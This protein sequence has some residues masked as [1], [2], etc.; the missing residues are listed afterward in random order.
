MTHYTESFDMTESEELEEI[1]AGI[2]WSLHTCDADVIQNAVKAYKFFR[3]FGFTSSDDAAEQLS[4]TAAEF[5]WIA[6]AL[7]SI[8]LIEFD[9]ATES[10]VCTDCD[11]N[12]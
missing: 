8:G 11:E 10:W 5:S 4:L 2:E 7:A 6:E 1:I 9:A 3:N 12:E